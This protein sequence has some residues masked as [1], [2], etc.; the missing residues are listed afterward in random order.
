MVG[1][2]LAAIQE[3]AIR[4]EQIGQIIGV[5]DAFNSGMNP[6]HGV[7]L[8]TDITLSGTLSDDEKPP[9]DR[10]VIVLFGGE[11]LKAE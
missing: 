6:A 7:G 1:L 11:A 4:G 3:G 8:Q 10:D 9:A 2:Q 5:R